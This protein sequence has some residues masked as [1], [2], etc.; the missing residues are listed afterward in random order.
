MINNLVRSLLSF[1]SINP[2]GGSMRA[3]SIMYTAR[4]TATGDHNGRVVCDDD[5]SHLD[6][7]LTKPKELGGLGGSGTN[8]EELF[9]A[10]YSA[11]FLAAM[12]LAA[13]NLKKSLPSASSVSAAV[14]IGKHDNGNY[15]FKVELTVKIPNAKQ[16][17]ADALVKAAHNICPYSHATRNNIDVK[18]K[19]IT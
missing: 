9:A 4:C 13:Q 17:D 6:V 19:T 5:R 14:S 1:R 18:I 8:P 7:K 11:C 16:A 15:G 12:G 2:L 10:G 3:F